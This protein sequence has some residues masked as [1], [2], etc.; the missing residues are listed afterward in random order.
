MD[1]TSGGLVSGNIV[2]TTMLIFAL[3]AASLRARILDGQGVFRCSTARVLCWLSWPL[4]MVVDALVLPLEQPLGN[5]VEI[6]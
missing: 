2:V 4:D 1:F 6:R 3:V 5:K